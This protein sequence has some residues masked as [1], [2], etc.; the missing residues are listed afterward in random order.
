MRLIFLGTGGLG[1]R[2]IGTHTDRAAP[3]RTSNA[4]VVQ[5]ASPYP[6]AILLDAGPDI[7]AQW[8]NWADAPPRPDAV[9]LTHGHFDHIGGMP[10]L[11]QLDPPMPVYG[12]QETLARLDQFAA[13]LWQGAKYDVDPYPL[14]D[15]ERSMVCGVSVETLSLHHSI[16]VTGFLLR[17]DGHCVAHLS[18]TGPMIEEGVRAAIRGCDVLVVDT[19]RVEKSPG[20]IGI[21]G[22]IALAREVEARCLVLTHLSDS[23]TA[24]VVAAITTEYPWVTFAHD[25]MVIDLSAVARDCAMQ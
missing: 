21:P 24:D 19:P 20:H 8:E 25:G 18:D 12:S 16:P 23:I 5:P 6:P 2:P 4:L 7:R 3:S 13:L 17:H 1:S 11:W 22:A 15:G 10:N 9:L 14:H